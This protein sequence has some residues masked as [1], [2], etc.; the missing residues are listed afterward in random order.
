MH[1]KMFDRVGEDFFV[2]YAV[3]HARLITPIV[4][5]PMVIELASAAGLLAIAP[6]E[7]SRTTTS[8][9]LG[10]VVLLWASTALLQ[11]PCH[12]RLADGFDIASYQKLVSSNWVRT[13]G[14]TA[15][16]GLTGYWCWQL[17][18]R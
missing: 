13:I 12:E 11:V 8:V 18:S 6:P 17:I 3:D 10:I 2:K 4:A 15:R 14:W 7:L 1:Y 9:G 5:I 16:G